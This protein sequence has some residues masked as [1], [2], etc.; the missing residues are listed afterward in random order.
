MTNYRYIERISGP[1]ILSASKNFRVIYVGGPR[2]VGKTTLLL[3]LSKQHKMGYVSL[4]DPEKRRL[5]K[6]DPGLFLQQFPPPL[7]IDEA[8][9]APELFPHIKMIVDR[10]K[11]NGL[12][13]LSGSQHFSMIRGLQESLAGRVGII[14][15]LGLSF[16]EKEGLAIPEHP[17][18]PTKLLPDCKI[19]WTLPDLFQHLFLGSFPALASGEVQDRERFYASY[20]QT[21]LDRD[22]TGLFG[23]Q[24]VDDF[25]RVLTIL[26]ART[27]QILNVTAIATEASLPVSTVRSWLS[28]LEATGILFLLKPYTSNLTKRV[29]RSPKIYI[30]DTGLVAFLT[31]WQSAQTL[32]HG[33]MAGALFETFVVSEILKSYQFRGKEAPIYFYRDKEKREVDLLFDIDG[34][35]YPLEIK[36]ASRVR[37]DDLKH[38]VYLREHTTNIGDAM[39]IGAYEQPMMFDRNTM[40]VPAWCIR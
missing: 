23:I 2:Q 17:F 22:V 3:H 24:N 33:A 27:A 7:F 35:M 18:S 16:A 6:T 39:V 32:M 40:L 20:I 21:Y 11:E 19:K 8:Q 5:A 34:M 10:H 12:Y 4:D 1:T 15:L 26:A 38:I 37:Q 28:I 13:W 25:H 31:K 9:Y 14:S 36:M 29:T 30:L